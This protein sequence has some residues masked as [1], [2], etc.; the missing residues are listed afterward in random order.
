MITLAGVSSRALLGSLMCLA[1]FLSCVT[2]P[3]ASLGVWDSGSLEE[4][5]W[6]PPALSEWD[7]KL[8]AA[9]W[10]LLQQFLA[11]S[12][13]SCPG[14]GFPPSL[15][16]LLLEG[17]LQTGD[18]SLALGVKDFLKQETPSQDT[19]GSWF[20]HQIGDKHFL[21]FQSLLLWMLDIPFFCYF[22]SAQP[23]V[24]PNVVRLM[25]T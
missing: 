20:L 16:T 22:K 3:F 7:D 5:I 25:L 4:I 18:I 12:W 8:W 24:S 21:D 23:E 17:T 9:P 2:K 15:N 10:A 6:L 1:C 19:S 11:L 14:D 13:Q